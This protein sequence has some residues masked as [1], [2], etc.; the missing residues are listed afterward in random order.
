MEYGIGCGLSIWRYE[1]DDIYL[2]IGGAF[3]NGIGDRMILPNGRDCRIW[4]AREIEGSSGY[5]GGGYTDEELLQMLNLLE[6]LN[7]SQCPANSSNIGGTCY[8]NSGYQVNDDKTG[9]VKKTEYSC[10]ENSQKDPEDETKC[11][12]IDGYMLNSK[13]DGCMRIPGPQQATSYRPKDARS[14]KQSFYDVPPE[15]HAY[16]EI[17]YLHEKGILD[18]YED[19]SFKPGDFVNRAELLKILIGGLHSQELKGE[20]GCFPDVNNEWFAKYVCAAKRLGWVDGYS[21][22]TFQPSNTVNRA[23]AIK[24]IVSSVTNDLNSSESLNTDVKWEDWFSPYTRKALELGIEESRGMF[25]PSE[26]LTR[27]GAATWIYNAIK[28]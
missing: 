15:H 12:C 10:P 8:C 17:E 14:K 25:Y 4:D 2:K 13:R 23:E 16:S 6:E 21:D 26:D 22:G 28:K 27:Y 9:C 20:T 1:G 24:I 19:G 7:N 3:L 11:I 18:G 5:S